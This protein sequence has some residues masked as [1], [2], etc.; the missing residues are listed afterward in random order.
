MTTS[1]GTTI[2]LAVRHRK[3]RVK[4]Q[5][6]Y[7]VWPTVHECPGAAI[8]HEGSSELRRKPGVVNSAAGGVG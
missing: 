1:I 6:A 5:N 8:V 7:A 4:H 2:K 3:T